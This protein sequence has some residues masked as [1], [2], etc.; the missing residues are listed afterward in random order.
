[1]G[2]GQDTGK[3]ITGDQIIIEGGTDGTKIGNLSDRMLV[4]SIIDP[5]SLESV[6]YHNKFANN[7]GSFDMN[8]DGDAAAQTFT[9]SPQDSSDSRD[10]IV[11]KFYIQFDDNGNIDL[12]A[13]GTITALTNGVLI[14]FKVNGTLHTFANLKDNLD[15]LSYFSFG[16]INQ[17][18]G[19]GF[20][21]G[22]FFSG[23]FDM[24]EPKMPLI[25]STDDGITVE[26][27]DDL[28]TLTRLRFG[29]HYYHIIS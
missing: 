21:K 2:I 8:V 17:N 9:V 5:N 25:E 4:S 13:F 10:W 16:G 26:I 18:T 19:A 15:I 14:K 6:M 24:I 22:N 11:S 27:R 23:S 29:I 1:M 20:V 28:S 12:N 3:D 7:A